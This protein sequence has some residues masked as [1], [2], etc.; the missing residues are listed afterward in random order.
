MRFLRFLFLLLVLAA[1]GAG[2]AF[3]IAGRGSG[4]AIEIRQPEKVIGQTANLDVAVTAPAGRLDS[5][6]IWIEQNGKTWPLFDLASPGSLAPQQEAADRIKLTRTFTR[7]DAPDLREGPLKLN[8][9]ASRP[10][11]FGYRTLTS[12]A[13]RDLEARFIPPRISVISTHHYVNLGG[14]EMVVYR[15]TPPDVQSGVRVGD[16]VYPGYSASGAGIPGEGLK[17]AFFALGQDQDLNTPIVA[18]ARDAAGNES[19]ASF[20]FRVFPKAFRRS[21]IEVDDRFLDRVVPAILAGSPELQANAADKVAAFL[22]ING[23]LRRMNAQKISGLTGKT[24][25]QMLWHGAF[26]PLVNSAIES[27]FADHRTYFYQGKEIDQQVHLGFDLAR[28]VNV[29]V[30]ASNDG[31]VVYAA[32]LGIYGN[33]VILDHGLGVQSLYAHLSSFDVGVGDR[34]RKGQSLGRSGMTGLAGGDHLHFSM[35]VNGRAVNAVEWWDPHWIE[36]RITRK[37]REAG[38]KVN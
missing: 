34:V 37:I 9:S 14:A 32:D 22:K 21:R 23:D 18:F 29:P 31:Q 2:V 8:V 17:V 20:D 35:L 11:L 36:D 3:Y 4:P 12:A 15:V 7:A 38:G 30:L 13:T 19:R 6:K 28:T 26:Q 25:P 16:E 24:S 10:T 33:C 5:F 1:L 27:S